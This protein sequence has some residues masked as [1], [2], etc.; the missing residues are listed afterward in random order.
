MLS[1]S[2]CMLCVWP[3][4]QVSDGNGESTMLLDHSQVQEGQ[5]L[6]RALCDI[7]AK[8]SACMPVLMTIKCV[9][10][11]DGTVLPEGQRVPKLARR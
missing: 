11:P 10:W 5:A 8:G 6:T 4:L 3:L 9:Q 1:T 2:A 7:Y